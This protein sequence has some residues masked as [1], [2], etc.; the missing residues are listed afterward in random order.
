MKSFAS[1]PA[2]S[3]KLVLD[4]SSSPAS[5]VPASP[6]QLPPDPVD[7]SADP[8]DALTPTEIEVQ[9]YNVQDNKKEC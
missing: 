3:E 6:S 2:G 4:G 8:P 1:L 9:K 7:A 5:T